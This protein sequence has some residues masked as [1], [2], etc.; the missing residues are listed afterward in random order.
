M[1]TQTHEVLCALDASTIHSWQFDTQETVFSGLIPRLPLFWSVNF[2][3]PGV[4][5]KSSTNQ[6]HNNQ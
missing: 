3:R 4:S 5:V 2:E 6:N 1:Q